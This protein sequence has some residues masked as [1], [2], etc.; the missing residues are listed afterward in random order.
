MSREGGA[1]DDDRRGGEG[2]DGKN[3]NQLPRRR[4]RG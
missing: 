3:N 2:A 4:I 1:N